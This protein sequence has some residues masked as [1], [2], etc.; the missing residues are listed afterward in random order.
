[1]EPTLTPEELHIL[2][3][4]LGVDKYGLGRMYRNDFCACGDNEIVCRALV[5]KGYMKQHLTTEMFP[6]FNCSVTESGKQAMLNE[7]PKPPKL[8]TSQKRYREFLSADSGMPFIEW[9]KASYGRRA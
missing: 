3:H 1:M 4:S 7:S 6:Y 2:Q 8:T 9:L 5:A